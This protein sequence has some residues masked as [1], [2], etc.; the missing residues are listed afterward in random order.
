M[1][2][3]VVLNTAHD[4]SRPGT[5][6]TKT[7]KPCIN[8]T[9]FSLSLNRFLFIKAGVYVN[10]YLHLSFSILFES[11]YLFQHSLDNTGGRK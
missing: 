6:I 4:I 8:R 11:S 10:V 3:Q 5:C 2:S 1:V 7:V 9:R